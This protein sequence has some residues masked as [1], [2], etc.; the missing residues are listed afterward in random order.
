[1]LKGGSVTR[2]LGGVGLV[3]RPR[4]EGPISGSK[5]NIKQNTKK[6][7]RIKIIGG[8]RPENILRT[9]RERLWGTLT[10]KSHLYVNVN[11]PFKKQRGNRAHQLPGRR[12]GE[13]REKSRT[14]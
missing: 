3:G 9:G 2:A 1:L 14:E 8:I 13:K 7:V 6:W 11:P 10:R 5:T 12:R 4:W